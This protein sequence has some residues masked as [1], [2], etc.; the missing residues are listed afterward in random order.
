MRGIEQVANS[1]PHD[2]TEWRL[3]VLDEAVRTYVQRS[4]RASV[5]PVIAAEQDARDY[6]ASRF[7]TAAI[8]YE[9]LAG[10]RHPDPAKVG[11]L[12]KRFPK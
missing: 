11:A 3:R 6:G 10:I 12:R 5:E 9:A 1:I 8:I 7:E 2:P 4:E